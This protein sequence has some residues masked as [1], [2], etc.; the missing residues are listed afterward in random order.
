MALLPPTFDWI[1]SVIQNGAQPSPAGFDTVQSVTSDS[2]GNV[3]ICGYTTSNSITIGPNSYNVPPI[4]NTAD[5]SYIAKL[6]SLGVLIWLRWID[7]AGSVITNKITIDST[8]TN[9]YVVGQTAQTPISI[10]SGPTTPATPAIIATYTNS[11]IGGTSA[12]F[13][14]KINS[15]GAPQWFLFF[16]APSTVENLISVAVNT[17]GDIYVCSEGTSIAG[18]AQLRIVN[19]SGAFTALYTAPATVSNKS[20]VAKINSASSPIWVDWIDGV[21][22]SSNNANEITTDS[23]GIVYITGNT[24]SATVTIYNQVPA[25][26]STYTNP[27]STGISAFLLVLSSLGSTQMFRF[28]SGVNTEEGISVST[29][30]TYGPPN[31]TTGPLGFMYITGKSNSPT[32][33]I[34]NGNGGVTIATYTSPTSPLNDA[35]FI[36]K[37]DTFLGIPNTII[38][39]GW[40]RWIQTVTG[41]DEPVEIT[42][43]SAGNIYVIGTTSDYNDPLDIYDGSTVPT[44]PSVIES[45]VPSG[46]GTGNST[47]TFA[48]KFNSSGDPQWILWIAGDG[49]DVGT[50][51]NVDS[52]DNIYISGTSNKPTIYLRGYDDFNTPF[53]SEDYVANDNSTWGFLLKLRQQLPPL[54]PSNPICYAK[55]TLIE[56][57]R[58]LLP[59]EDIKLS[60]KVRTYGRIAET[61]FRPVH[62]VP[63]K[64]LTRIGDTRIKNR[65]AK[66]KFIGHFST[67]GMY[68]ETAPICITAGALGNSKPDRDLFVSPNHSMLVGDRMIFAKDMVNDISIYQDM[69]FETIEYY[70][71]LSDDHYIINANGAMSETLGTEELVLFETMI[72]AQSKVYEPLALENKYQ[73]QDIAT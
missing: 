25:L 62:G 43:D 31:V 71:I 35:A 14:F 15:L 24:N 16:D 2:A 44:V 61:M 58:G 51:I 22:S 29:F 17:A 13:L 46:V 40:L 63:F 67:K 18:P 36:I 38:V 60:D 42:T 11:T 7:G 34:V 54:P 72:Y 41:S 4:V 53:L 5:T 59:I 21:S 47:E 57:D 30:G 23:S 3:Y 6:D 27:L 8:G 32:L 66:I 69:S 1:E 9:I 37:L 49:G 39:S 73:L 26:L 20:F 28:F 45:F 70:H 33:S 64:T 68:G 50:G 65:F 56:T 10:Y 52:N 12:G 19:G 48:L 55:G